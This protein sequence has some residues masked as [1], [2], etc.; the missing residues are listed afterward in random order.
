MNKAQK[1]EEDI[2]LMSQPEES[3]GSLPDWGPG[4]DEDD[5]HDAVETETGETR[6]GFE[7]PEADVRSNSWR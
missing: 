1:V 5:D 3:V 4:K 7:K 6:H 2:K